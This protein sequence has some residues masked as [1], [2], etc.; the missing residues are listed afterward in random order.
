MLRNASNFKIRL[1]GIKGEEKNYSILFDCSIPAFP[2]QHCFCQGGPQLRRG[3]QLRRKLFFA[4]FGRVLGFFIFQEQRKLFLQKLRQL[5]KQWRLYRLVIFKIR[6]LFV[7][8]LIIHGFRQYKEQQRVYGFILFQNS[9]IF[10]KFTKEY[11]RF[12][13]CRKLKQVLKNREHCKEYLHAGPIQ[14][15]NVKG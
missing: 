13:L 11:A 12:I 1:W 14:E 9:F 2:I 6:K 10:R 5:K 15:G 7:R 4:Q 3:A 8:R